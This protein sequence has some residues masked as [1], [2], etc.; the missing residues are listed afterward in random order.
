MQATRTKDTTTRKRG[1]RTVRDLVAELEARDIS[2]RIQRARK[3][4]G[5]TQEQ[6]ADLLEVIPRSVQNYESG[7]VPWNKINAIGKITGKSPEWLLHGDAPDPFEGRPAAQ[8]PDVH[9]ELQ[10][11]RQMVAANQDALLQLQ[12]TLAG[13]EGIREELM[14]LIADL[15]SQLAHASSGN[16]PGARRSQP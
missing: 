10:D 16:R 13:Q 12:E 4:A 11:L 15:R 7:R 8:Q 6:L 1:G 14:L 5:L 9:A 3:E 2:A